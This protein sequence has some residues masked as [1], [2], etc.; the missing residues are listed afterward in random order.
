MSRAYGR[1]RHGRAHGNGRGHGHGGHVDRHRRA[2]SRKN[3]VNKNAYSARGCEYYHSASRLFLRC[4][5]LRARL[6]ATQ[7]S[8][9]LCLNCVRAAYL[10]L[11]DNLPKTS[12]EAID[13]HHLKL[14]NSPRSTHSCLRKVY[15]AII[16]HHPIQERTMKHCVFCSIVPPYL[17]KKLA[18]NPDPRIRDRAI[19]T[20]EATD[21][22]RTVRSAM[23][24]TLN[25]A[26]PAA[27]V[28]AQKVRRVFDCQDTSDLSRQ[29]VMQEGGQLPADVAVQEAYDYAGVTWD[30]YN[31]IFN[32]NSIDN[33]GLTVVS[34]V[35]YS[36]NGAGFDNALWNGQQMIYGDGGELFGRMTQ[37]LDVVGHE[38]T[39][40]VTQY[41]AGLPY[42][43]QSGA[44]N[45]SMSDVFGVVVR[46]W[47]EQQ[48]DP[49]TA[50]W[51][52]GEG[53]LLAGGALR[54]MKA[55]GTANPDDPQPAH[56]KDYVNLPNSPQGDYGGVH[57]NSGIPN[58]AFYLAAVAIGKPAWET[59][60]RIWYITLTQR[61]KGDTD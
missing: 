48:S 15:V 11:R 30:F 6:P 31:S 2:P 54:S 18:E 43:S 28:P 26:S 45:E 3:S 9:M 21:R 38:L 16:E 56:M 19:A 4:S 22:A 13:S 52:V 25:V 24:R 8:R 50:N 12:L 29:L 44:L 32:R 37:C 53:L 60:A 20:L 51:L 27:A 39:H 47:H 5:R 55:P 33:R 59:A 57:Y 46:Q 61:L 36:E 17:L 7:Q 42:Q 40:G 49:A 23:A 10:R 1:G 35:H 41:S 58:H 14:H 34:S